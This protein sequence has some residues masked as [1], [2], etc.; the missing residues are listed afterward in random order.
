MSGVMAIFVVP[1]QCVQYRLRTLYLLVVM[2]T[3]T[4]CPWR[5]RLRL[6]PL[7]DAGGHPVWV[8]GRVTGP[9]PGPGVVLTVGIAEAPFAPVLPLAVD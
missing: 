7:P 6:R 9:G 5:A 1:P 8:R 3:W 2:V 4:R